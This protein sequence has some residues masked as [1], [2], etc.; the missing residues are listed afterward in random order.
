MSLPATGLLQFADLVL[1]CDRPLPEL[2]GA[3]AGRPADVHIAWTD[4]RTS[5]VAWIQ[6]WASDGL[7]LGLAGLDYVVDFPE[8][9]RFLISPDG[10]R[11]T[12]L[13]PAAAPEATVRHYLLNQVLPLVLNRFGRFVIHASAVSWRDGVIAFVGRTGSGKS[14]LAA[15]CVSL[16]ASIVTD[17]SLVLTP[18]DAGANW[19]AVPSYPALRVWPE[20]L[21]L[22]GWSERR[23]QTTPHVSD[24]LRLTLWREPPAFE[25]RTLPLRQVLLVSVGAEGDGPR[26]AHGSSVAVALASQLFRLDVR[27][28]GESRRLLDR[29]VALASAVPVARLEVAGGPPELRSVASRVLTEAG[30]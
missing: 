11:V 20:S 14:T 23:W 16:G 3:A 8:E 2:P 9:A 1:A 22:L 5:E 24:K 4:L 17:D 21:P 15:A 26:P 13:W 28:A 30:W 27:D 12:V 10:R 29:V 19:L 6:Q 25:T 7:R 18:P